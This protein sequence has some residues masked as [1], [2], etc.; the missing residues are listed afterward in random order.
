MKK[1]LIQIPIISFIL[2]CISLAIYT[3]GIYIS[4][5][6]QKTDAVYVWGDSQM[7]QGLDIL[8]LSTELQLPILSSA[9][10]GS[11]IYDFLISAECIPS[12]STCIIALPECALYRTPDADYNQTGFS[13]TSIWKLYEC[14]C[15]FEEYYRIANL[16]RNKLYYEP[17]ST[18]NQLYEYASKIVCPE[19][20]NGFC[21]MFNKE[22]DF[23]QWKQKAYKYGLSNLANKK[24]RLILIQ[25]PFHEQVEE[26]A[27]GS[28]NRNM[29]DNLRKELVAQ[30]R[31]EVHQVKLES[32]SL[33]MHDLSHLNEIG[34]RLVTNHVSEIIR[35]SKNNLFIK[36][37]L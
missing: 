15:P 13:F 10:H 2:I 16:N 35:S 24:C 12:Q 11:G 30:Y 31:L 17:F 4:Q 9:R 23:S 27:Q 26:C 6:D 25:F 14:G 20:L 1:F 36:I 34:A 3:I 8:S 18:S 5:Y 19:P 37:E 28:Y 32:D 33:L 29:T 21:E 22:T 7:Y